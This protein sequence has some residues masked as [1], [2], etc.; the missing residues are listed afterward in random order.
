MEKNKLKRVI[1]LNKIRSLLFV[2]ILFSITTGVQKVDGSDG[3]FIKKEISTTYSYYRVSKN[4]TL[5]KIVDDYNFKKDKR[6]F[7]AEIIKIN[8][9]KGN[10][11]PGDVIVI[12]NN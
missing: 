11:M 10:I 12:P 5:W 1:K 4:D 2:L 9:I 3:K 6:E 7:I 8:N